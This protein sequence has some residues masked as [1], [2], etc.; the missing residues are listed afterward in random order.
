MPLLKKKWEYDDSRT[1]LWPDQL[2][3]VDHLAFSLGPG[4]ANKNFIGIV[5]G[6]QRTADQ[7]T[8]NLRLNEIGVP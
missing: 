6:E 8:S 7:S 1:N 4:A 5:E 3:L 2:G